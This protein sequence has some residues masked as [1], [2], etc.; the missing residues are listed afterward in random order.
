MDKGLS[1]C[2]GNQ[3]T[4]GSVVAQRC[5][6]PPRNLIVASYRSCILH[7]LHALCDQS[8]GLQNG[9]LADGLPPGIN[10]QV[11]EKVHFFNANLFHFLICPPSVD[12]VCALHWT[13]KLPSPRGYTS[14]LPLTVGC[15]VSGTTIR[16]SVCEQCIPAPSLPPLH[17]PTGWVLPS[18]EGRSRPH[19]AA[20]LCFPNP[21]PLERDSG[22]HGFAVWCGLVLSPK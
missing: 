12:M 17:L 5:R 14:L 15:H 21:F 7:A 20:E 16:A 4:K 18:L 22:K 19:P 8:S 9:V 10:I 2:A 11:V 1:A 13:Y 6:F 3:R